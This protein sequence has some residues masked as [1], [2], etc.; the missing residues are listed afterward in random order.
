MKMRKTIFLILSV[1]WMGVIFFQSAK[2]ADRSA[3]ES[4][5]LIIFVGEHFVPG[6]DNWDEMKKQKFVEKYDHP[7]RKAAHVTEYAI[8]AML[9][10]GVFYEKSDSGKNAGKMPMSG[11][12]SWIIAT[13]YAATDEFHQTFV[14]GRS[15]EIK[16]VCFD[17][18]GALIGIFVALLLAIVIK[19]VFIKAGGCRKEDQ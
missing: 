4:G 9:L 12:L 18:G 3:A 8:L 11:V 2:V 6:F 17:S 5:G 15:G 19:Y 1:I 16:D 10:M 14:P 7:V 13:L